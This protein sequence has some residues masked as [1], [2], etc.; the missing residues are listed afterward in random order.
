MRTADALGELQRLRRPVIETGEAVA[1]LDVSPTRASQILR[2]LEHAG[3]VARLKH[4]LWLLEPDVDPFVI[5]P[6]LTAPF[7]AYVSLWSALSKHGMIEQIP[8][9]V[10]VCSL[11]RPQKV[12]TTRATYTIH[13]LA[14]EVFGG[15]TGTSDTGYLA[16]PEK[17]LFDSV[18]LPLARR[19]RLFLPELELTTDFDRGELDAWKDRIR[20]PW[21]RSAVSRELER[22]LVSTSASARRRGG[23]PSS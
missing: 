5:P 3:V 12:K 19:R 18:Y 10:F 9:T 20:A 15:Y 6:Y 2:S 17:A 14:A 11:G 16:T 13:H 21:L 8:R 23:L 4:G 22:L 1:R 7:S